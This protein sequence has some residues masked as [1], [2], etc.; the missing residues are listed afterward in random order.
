[1]QNFDVLTWPSQSHDLNLI[2]HMWAIVKR[3]LNE[4]LVQAKGMLK[5]W[6]RVQGFFN[7][8]T[9]A[10]CQKLYQSMSNYIQVVLG[11]KGGWT[12]Y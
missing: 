10:K 3:R 4:N 5:L 2:E 9:L 6:E 12:N 1:M 8:I 11:S 7:S